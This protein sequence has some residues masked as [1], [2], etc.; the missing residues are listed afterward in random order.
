MQG[1][2]LTLLNIKPG[3]LLEVFADAG[4]DDVKG[5]PCDCLAVLQALALQYGQEGVVAAG[6]VDHGVSWVYE[7]LQLLGDYVQM[8][9]FGEVPAV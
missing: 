8:L 4:G 5:T 2:G 9:C 3:D 6:E 1:G 7:H